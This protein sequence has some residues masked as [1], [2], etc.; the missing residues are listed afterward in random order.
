M[1]RLSTFV[2]SLLLLA[3]G[4]LAQ[5]ADL[6]YSN[7]LQYY[8]GPAQ[9]GVNVFEAPKEAGPAFDGLTAHIGGD[10]AIQFQGLDQSN[11]A[12]TFVGL[13][14]NFTLP[15]ANLN[16]DVQIASG[17]RM[18]LRTY[19]SSRHHTEAYVKGGY[20]QV[21]NLDFIQDG[22]LASAMDVTRFRFGMDEI[23]FGDTHF[24][25]SDNAATVYNPFVGN[26]LMD[27][28]TTEPF[29][30]VSVLK[31][32]FIGVAGLSNG[33]LN[34]SPTPGDNGVAVY[35]KL[36][37]DTQ[38]NDQLR[39]R[40]TGSVYHSTDGGTRDY[41]YGGDRAGARYY[42]VLEVVD[43]ERPSDFLPRFSPGFPHH[44]AVQVNPFIAFMGAEFFGV[45]ERSMGGLDGAGA[46]TQLGGEL[47]YR[48]GA[49]EDFYLGG[50]Y[51]TVTGSATDGGAEVDIQ[52]VNVGGGWFLTPNVLAKVEYVNQTYDGDA[53]TGNAKFEGAEFSGV[54][55]EA[56]ISF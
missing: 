15:T 56:A 13:A 26:Y 45:F 30:E 50:R 51:N 5:P 16:L 33:R 55:M 36:G 12:G 44:T 11:D 4:A 40:L 48:I 27:A 9:T 38:V 1:A 10:F 43:E 52:R 25:R 21:D 49:D 46:F 17:M 19:L 18:H 23:N 28:F 31:D 32:G 47:V 14:P 7:D 42:N 37:V 6:E 41:I 24:R 20:F 34:Q 8:R 2:L 35:G 39:A 53:Y 29:A 22:F 3:G 54:V